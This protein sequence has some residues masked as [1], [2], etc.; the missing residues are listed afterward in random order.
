[1][2]PGSRACRLEAKLDGEITTYTFPAVRAQS[3][4]FAASKA[5]GHVDPESISDGFW[6]L[7]EGAGLPP[8]HPRTFLTHCGMAP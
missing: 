4:P 8:P 3:P 1:M 7:G 6:V 5:A 2:L